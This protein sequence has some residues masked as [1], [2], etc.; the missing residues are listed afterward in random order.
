M[1]LDAYKKTLDGLDETVSALYKE[2]DGGFTLDV[3]DV[4]T[5]SGAAYGLGDFGGL[6]SALVS[7]RANSSQYKADLA[8]YNGIDIESATAAIDFQSKYTGKT[9]DDFEGKLAEMRTEFDG[10]LGLANDATNAAVNA[11]NDFQLGHVVDAALM[12][13]EDIKPS[14]SKFLRREIMDSVSI[15]DTGVFIKDAN[16]NARMSAQASNT[17]NMN[18]GELIDSMASNVDVYGGFFAAQGAGSGSGNN[19]NQGKQSS[20]GLLNKSEFQALGETEKNAEYRKN[21]AHYGPLV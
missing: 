16:G 10:K 4:T 19:S 5:E 1:A 12:G 2:V 8:K 21:P 9:N 15:N 20:G 6:K 17:G 14:M 13:R 11:K 18:V 7:E 3:T